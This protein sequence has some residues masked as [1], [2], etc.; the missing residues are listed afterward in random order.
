MV[1]V[2]L[3]YSLPWRL[4]NI[5][6]FSFIRQLISVSKRISLSTHLRCVSVLGAAV[7]LCV[8]FFVEPSERQFIA[9]DAESLRAQI[10]I[11]YSSVLGSLSGL[12]SLENKVVAEIVDAI[13]GD[14]EEESNVDESN[15][16]DNTD[17]SS[18]FSEEDFDELPEEDEYMVD[19]STVYS[20]ET[21]D[22]LERL[23]QSEAATEDFD[24]RVL[25]ADVVLNRV[26]TG[27]WGNDILS[28]IESPGQFIPVANGAY[29]NAEVDHLTKDAVISALSGNDGSKGAIYFQKSAATVWGDKEFLFRHGSHSFYK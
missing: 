2:V 4:R 25:V 26:D 7:L 11:E 28:V 20:P 23:V 16:T 15:D 10:I 22:A 12:D 6:M 17:L 5:F 27:V 19:V 18:L 13:P 3:K 8:S 21:V 24:G 9:D 29:K 14:I 1:I